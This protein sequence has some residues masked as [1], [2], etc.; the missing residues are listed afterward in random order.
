MKTKVNKYYGKVALVLPG[1]LFRIRLNNSEVVVL[2]YL[3]GKMTKNFIKPE[4]EDGVEIEMSPT[5]ITKGRI[6][7]RMK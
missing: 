5:D 3:S 4:L 6:V 1:G 7:R 2:C